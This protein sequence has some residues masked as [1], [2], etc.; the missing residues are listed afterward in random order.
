M[1]VK[2]ILASASPR[3]LA[4]L[5]QIG[6]SADVIKPEG[7][8]ELDGSSQSASETVRYNAMGKA[9]IIAD[10]IISNDE[11]VVVGA[12][13]V[14]E[15]DDV[16]L[17]KPLNQEDARSML[18]RLSGKAH[19]VLTGVAVIYQNKAI[20]EKVTTE[21]VFRKLTAIEIETYLDT[22]ES[23]DKA[24]AY[25]IQGRGAILVE[26]I[27]GCYNN[28]VGLPVTKLYEML[29]NMEVRGF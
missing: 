27:N 11:I 1:G 25:G 28:V 16:I 18:E 17:G 12:D 21:V 3:R 8:I 4:L 13:T 19:H 6:I 23:F 10:N 24:G 29:Q 2:V 5:K 26:K 7:F 15:L 9:K 20:F 22:S 14:V